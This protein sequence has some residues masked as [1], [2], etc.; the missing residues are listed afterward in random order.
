MNAVVPCLIRTLIQLAAKEAAQIDR[1]GVVTP[2][3]RASQPA[4][5]APAYVLFA[6]YEGSYARR[7]RRLLRL[8][9]TKLNLTTRKPTYPISAKGQ[10]PPA[11]K[12][13][14][15]VC[16]DADKPAPAIN[17]RARG[18]AFFHHRFEK[19]TGGIPSKSRTSN[20]LRFGYFSIASWNAS[21]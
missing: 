19:S 9:R 3:G 18:A 6:S 7:F 10:H 15:Q 1:L 21:L 16:S 8:Q 4:E 11:I 17:R 2:L 14:V 12:T 5:H 20:A 13:Q